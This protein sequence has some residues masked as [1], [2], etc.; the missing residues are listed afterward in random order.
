MVDKAIIVNKLKC[1]RNKDQKQIVKGI[2]FSLAEGESLAIIGESGSGKTISMLSTLGLLPANQISVSGSCKL[3]GKE[4]INLKEQELNSIR[5]KDVGFIFQE[6]LTALN[7]LHKVKDQIAEAITIH[8]PKINQQTLETRISNLLK[9]VDMD[10]TL[11]NQNPYPHIL[12]GGQ[13]QRIMIAIAL[14]NNPRLLIADEPTSA[15]DPFTANSLITL[16]KDIQKS[17]GLSI[18]F[19][20]HDLKLAETFANYALVMRKGKVVEYG[21]IK[22][23]IYSPSHSYTKQLFEV[24]NSKIDLVAPDKNYVLTVRNMKTIVPRNPNS[25]F[26]QGQRVLINNLT[27]ALREGQT[28]GIIGKSGAGKT[29]FAMSL[30]GIIRSIAKIKLGLNIYNRYKRDLSFRRQVQIVFQDPF[31]S[32]NPR[33]TILEI[34]SEG[35]KSLKINHPLSFYQELLEKVNLHDLSLTSFPHE[36]SGGQRQRIAIA[37]ALAV[38]PKILILDEPTSAL[39]KPSELKI[40]MLLAHLQKTQRLSYILISHDY[41][42]ISKMSHSVMTLADGKLNMQPTSP[43]PL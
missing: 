27:F 22:D 5:G 18:I 31:A 8:S 9:E 40:L 28:L 43:K 42:V 2:S 32:L 41:N 34:L 24:Y 7:P 16:L 29:V 37:R 39:D 33:M 12:S 35:P 19:I 11:L 4:L 26:F 14:A 21:P 38:N 13:R 23:I 30:L 6:P 10:I 1:F 3:Y 36:L 15:L 20:T 17:R 25:W